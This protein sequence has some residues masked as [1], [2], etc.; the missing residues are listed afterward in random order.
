MVA[1]M[2]EIAFAV[3]GLSSRT[4]NLSRNQIPLSMTNVVP[5]TMA[6]FSNSRCLI[7]TRRRGSGTRLSTLWTTVTSAVYEGLRGALAGAGVD[8]HRT[9]PPLAP[10]HPD[11][12]VG[13]R[14]DPL[15][16]RPPPEHHGEQRADDHAAEE[17]GGLLDEQA[18]VRDLQV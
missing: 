15:L 9:Q 10:R 11:A 14:E 6:N 18:D 2:I 12:G 3:I 17:V 7:R 8:G 16:E 1:T 5:P 13:L 4:V